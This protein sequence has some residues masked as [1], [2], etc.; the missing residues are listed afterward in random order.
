MPRCVRACVHEVQHRA[1]VVGRGHAA[2]WPSLHGDGDPVLGY[3]CW[4]RLVG[5]FFTVGVG[6]GDGV[7][8]VV[9]SIFCEGWMGFSC[10]VRREKDLR[11]FQ[12]GL[13]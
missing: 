1:V 9:L 13:T 5:F 7:A 2:G 4:S 11:E 6:V 12:R 3:G 8:P 10:C